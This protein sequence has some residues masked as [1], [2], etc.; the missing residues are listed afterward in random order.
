MASTAPPGGAQSQPQSTSPNEAPLSWEGDKM[1][2]PI[3]LTQHIQVCSATAVCSHRFNIYI[4]DYCH[5]R[6]FKKTAR[7]LLAEADIPADSKPP[8]NARQ[9]LLFEQVVYCP[10]LD[11]SDVFFSFLRWWSVFWVLFS[12]K[13]NGNGTEDAMLYTQVCVRL[14]CLPKVG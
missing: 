4:Y 7:E 1:C 3:F 9:G 6:G 8:I 12:A 10:L 11:F 13:A 14:L 5:K 2:V